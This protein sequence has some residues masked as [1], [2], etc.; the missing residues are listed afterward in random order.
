ME[1]KARSRPKSNNVVFPFSTMNA[2]IYLVAYFL[3]GHSVSD[4]KNCFNHRVLELADLY[5]CQNMHHN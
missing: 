2:N 5:I 1:T 4:E 3:L